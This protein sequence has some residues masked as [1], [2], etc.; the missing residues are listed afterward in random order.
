MPVMGGASSSDRALRRVREPAIGQ[1]A[2]AWKAV[3][4][5]DTATIRGGYG[6]G[7]HPASASNVFKRIEHGS[8][9]AT[10]CRLPFSSR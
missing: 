8:S 3:P 7:A 9:M 1:G 10:Y 4:P 2:E 5:R 6:T